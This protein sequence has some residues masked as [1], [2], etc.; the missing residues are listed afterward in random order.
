MK[1]KCFGAINLNFFVS[2]VCARL[3]LCIDFVFCKICF[4]LRTT[5]RVQ[6]WRIE[7]LAPPPSISLP[8]I[9][10]LRVWLWLHPLCSDCWSWWTV[11]LHHPTSDL[12]SRPIQSPPALDRGVGGMEG[13]EVIKAFICQSVFGAAD[14]D[15]ERSRLSCCFNIWNKLW[16]IPPESSL[17][18]DRQNIRLQ[19]G[20]EHFK[21]DWHPLHHWSRLRIQ[22]KAISQSYK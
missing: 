20:W 21:E 5:V 19:A 22:T 18:T 15:R 17:T 11:S 12:C 7:V 6:W 9:D 16:M 8:L 14:N 4:T 3:R 1:I 10:P 13:V 2:T